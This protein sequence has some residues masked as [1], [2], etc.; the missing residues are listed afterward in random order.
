MAKKFL[1]IGVIGPNSGLCNKALYEFGIKAGHRLSTPERIF[2]S[3]GMGGFME[4]FFKGVKSS[5]QTFEG[6]TIGILPGYDPKEANTFTDIVI[7]TGMGL[8]RNILIINSSDVV[9][10]AGGGAGTLS[11]LA[12]AWQKNKKVICLT[13]F[14]GWSKELAGKRLDKRHEATFLEAKSIEDIENHLRNFKS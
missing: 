13:T 10:A 3:G 2:I 6:Q 4:A 7:P 5:D 14:E 8:A 9:I 12:F 11:E 1:Q